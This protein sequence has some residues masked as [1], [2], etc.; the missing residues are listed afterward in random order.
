[1][2]KY[3]KNPLYTKIFNEKIESDDSIDCPF[4]RCFNEFKRHK[5][6]VILT[7]REVL[8]DYSEKHECNA[9]LMPEKFSTMF[10]SL[11]LS[12]D[13]PFKSFFDKKIVNILESGQY[14]E[15]TK[16]HSRLNGKCSEASVSA[17]SDISANSI[18]LSQFSAV[19]VALY[20]GLAVSVVIFCI[21]IICVTKRG[22]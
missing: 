2:F 9:Y 6:V 13:C 10:P 7:T 8:L 20:I 16:R 19:F 3:S 18:S 1:M 5:D 17:S 12:K 22:I 14:Q 15:W 21:E 11:A 4:M